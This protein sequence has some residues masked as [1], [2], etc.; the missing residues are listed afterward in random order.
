MGNCAV[1]YERAQKQPVSSSIYGWLQLPCSFRFVYCVTNEREMNAK[2][3]LDP[4][5]R[6]DNLESLELH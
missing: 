3:V 1:T 4:M 5:Q 6:S 2:H